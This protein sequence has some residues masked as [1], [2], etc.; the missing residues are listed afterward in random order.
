M[1]PSYPIWASLASGAP[2]VPLSSAPHTVQPA[3][4]YQTVMFPQQQ[5]LVP[6]SQG[7]AYFLPPGQYL[8]PYVPSAQQFPVAS[9]PMS[10]YFSTYDDSSSAYVEM[11]EK[12]TLP[13]PLHIW[14]EPK[15]LSDCDLSPPPGAPYYSTQA[16]YQQHK[17]ER[18][19]IT[20]RDPNQGG[21]DMM[22]EV[23]SGA[24]N[25]AEVQVTAPVPEPEVSV[26]QPENAPVLNGLP[27][28]P[29]ELLEEKEEGERNPVT[30]PVMEPEVPQALQSAPAVV[31]A[32][33]TPVK[34]EAAVFSSSSPIDE[35]IMQG[36]Q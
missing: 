2:W 22:E 11:K 29:E 36:F 16:E 10:L 4:L 31:P 13:F 21:K 25:C 33:V 24:R 17:K 8:P 6:D 28:D 12:K 26:D 3:R 5:L 34:K 23:M 15:V 32:P 19:Q 7:A 14:A 18:K 35:T 9:A 1:A 30:E 20:I 27:Q